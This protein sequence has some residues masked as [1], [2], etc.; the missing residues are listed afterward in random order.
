MIP[1]K[2]AVAVQCCAGLGLLLATQPLS[3][4][5]APAATPPAAPGLTNAQAPAPGPR[6][7]GPLTDADKAAIASLTNL[8]AWKPGAGDGDYTA[9]GPHQP[10][11][12]NEHRDNVP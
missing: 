3:A 2:F 9:V 1:K 5:D 10:A 7:G 11:P 4:A 8:P 12:E 6:R